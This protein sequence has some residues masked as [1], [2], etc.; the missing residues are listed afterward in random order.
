[1]AKYLLLIL[2]LSAGIPV[3]NA[4][5]Y[6]QN[7]IDCTIR[8]ALQKITVLEKIISAFI[9]IVKS[10]IQCLISQADKKC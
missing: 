6:I 7:P 1:M 10:G 4:M 5:R 9:K 8:E 3:F 2:K